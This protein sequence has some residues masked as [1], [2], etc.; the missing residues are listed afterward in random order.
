M[1]DIEQ[2][3]Q[4]ILTEQGQIVSIKGAFAY[5]QVQAQSGCQGCASSSHCGTS[6]L[7]GYFKRGSRGLIKVHN[8][9]NG[10]VG[11]YVQLKLDQS[12]LVKQAFL[13]YGSPLLGLFMFAVLFK[14][15]GSSL[16]ELNDGVQEIAIIIGGFCGIGL[17]WYFSHKVYR[18]TLPEM[19]LILKPQELG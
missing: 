16:F 3:T 12:N 7:A 11:D 1:S 4:R 2:S 5:V 8:R 13:A 19:V 18:P 17:G 15:L 6:A 10:C 9:V 14:F